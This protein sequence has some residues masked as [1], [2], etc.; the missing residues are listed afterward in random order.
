MASGGDAST[1]EK[2][3]D[4]ETYDVEDNESEPK[5]DKEA[6]DG[7]TK[8]ESPMVAY[9]EQKFSK[10]LDAM[11][12]MFPGSGPLSCVLG[13][14]SKQALRRRFLSL[15]GSRAHSPGP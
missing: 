2:A 4:A 9:L 11:Q 15:R 10:S 13:M 12:S 3:K 5:P 14:F 8:A 7:A 6:P 1:S